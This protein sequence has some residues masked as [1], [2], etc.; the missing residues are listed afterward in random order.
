MDR[1]AAF[2]L[3]PNDILV[4]VASGSGPD[5]LFSIIDF[6][7]PSGDAGDWQI[8]VVEPSTTP[9]AFDL[10]IKGA[11]AWGPVPPR[12]PNILAL[13]ML[14]IGFA[15][16][17]FVGYRTRRLDRRAKHTDAV[18][19]W[20]GRHEAVSLFADVISNDRFTSISLKNHVFRRPRYASAAAVSE[21]KP[22]AP[23]HVAKTGAGRGM[24]F[25]SF[26]RFWAVAANRNS[27]LAPFG[28]RRRNRSSLRMRFR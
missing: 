7:V 10:A 28:P 24:S 17:G 11:S 2:Q 1:V 20:R 21:A 19:C 27:S 4:A 9:Y 15:G 18:L 13:A 22:G 23:P 3:D 5:G 25:A 8:Q 6:T 14:L 16:V 26:R 12:S